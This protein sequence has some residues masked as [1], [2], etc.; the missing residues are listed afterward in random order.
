MLR[1]FSRR[2]GQ[3]VNTDRRRGPDGVRVKHWLN[4]NSLKLYDKG[5]VLRSE[6]TINKT[7]DF[8]AW[9]SSELKPHGEKQWRILRRTVADVPRRAE[10]SRAACAR[11]LEALAAVEG[12]TPLRQESRR[13]CRAKRKAGRR[14]RALRPFGEDLPLL[15]AIN[16]LELAIAG[17]KNADL[18]K[19]FYPQSRGPKQPKK[20]SAAVSRK[21]ALLRAHGLIRRVPKRHLYHA[22]S[23]GRRAITA[24]LAAQQASVEELTKLAA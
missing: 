9:R 15:Q 2:N 19:L 14:H 1:F 5:S 6:V 22:T 16:R 11:H 23:K 10:V 17:F 18:L 4:E 13:L 20:Q 24:L 8:R 12:K 3:D 7:R 21:L